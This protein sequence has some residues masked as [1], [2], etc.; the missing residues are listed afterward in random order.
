MKECGIFDQLKERYWYQNGKREYY[1][2]RKTKSGEPMRL[3]STISVMIVL[4]VGFVPASIAFL[5][6]SAMKKNK[7]L[8]TFGGKI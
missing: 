3:S 8:K 6:E 5:F 7:K 1:K 4:G 2:P